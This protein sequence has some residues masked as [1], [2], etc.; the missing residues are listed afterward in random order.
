MVV[1]TESSIRKKPSTGLDRSR[2]IKINQSLAGFGL[3]ATLETKVGTV[4]D[5]A[6][7]GVDHAESVQIAVVLRHLVAGQRDPSHGDP[8]HGDPSHGDPS[9]GDPSH[10]DPSHGDPSH[11]DPSVTTSEGPT[12]PGVLQAEVQLT[13]EGNIAYV[14]ADVIVLPEIGA[15]P[16]VH[17]TVS[18]GTTDALMVVDMV[19]KDAKAGLC[20]QCQAVSAVFAVTTQLEAVQVVVDVDVPEQFV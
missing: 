16:V 1:Q 19:T 4:H 3:A 13:E 7:V 11:G 10:G 15:R 14:G 18:I 2:V 17:S 6:A 8:S 20:E 5:E 9:H 12:A